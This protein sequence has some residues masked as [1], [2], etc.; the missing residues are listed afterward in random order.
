MGD[1][2]VLN[3]AKTLHTPNAVVVREVGNRVGVIKYT[4][5]NANEMPNLAISTNVAIK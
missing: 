2:I 4:R 5:L 3:L 1:K